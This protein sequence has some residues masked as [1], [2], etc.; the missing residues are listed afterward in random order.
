MIFGRELHLPFGQLLL[1]QKV[2]LFELCDEEYLGLVDLGVGQLESYKTPLLIVQS[3][4]IHC[5]IIGE[6]L[7]KAISWTLWAGHSLIT[8]N[9][10]HVI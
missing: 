2:L 1:L 10:L 3:Y 7:V 6:C 5:L 8:A 4:L 9:L